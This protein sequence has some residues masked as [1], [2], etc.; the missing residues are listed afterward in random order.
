MIITPKKIIFIGF[1]IRFFNSFYNGFIGLTIGASEDSI[2]FHV[3]AANPWYDPEK[4]SI[5]RSDS[6]IFNGSYIYI[7]FLEK[8][9][10]ITTDHLFIGSFSSTIIWLLSA[11]LLN[12]TAD[13]L[14]IIKKHQKIMFLIY[15]LLPSA[16]LYTSIP[17]REPLQLFFVNLVIYLF[18]NIYYRKYGGIFYWLLA[19]IAVFMLG[20]LHYSFIFSGLIG[21]LLLLFFIFYKNIKSK[22]IYGL[23]LSVLLVASYI[24][25][26]SLFSNLYDLE[27]ADQIAKYQFGLI[28][29]EYVRAV[30]RTTIEIN[31][32][33]GLMIFIP[34]A[35]FQYLIEPLPHRISTIMDF[36]LFLENIIRI[37]L[38]Y[39]AFVIFRNKK[40]NDFQLFII[41]FYLSIEIIWSLGVNNWGTASR[42]HIPSTGL[43]CLCAFMYENKHN[44]KYI[45]YKDSQDFIVNE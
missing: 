39:N 11:L 37:Y 29:A 4:Y 20:S 25:I 33:G 12:R 45:F 17:L 22:I 28:N 21:L 10:Y 40:S 2:A 31:N 44:K 30:Y 35:F 34:Q 18:I 9:Y 13:S 7:K 19:I 27:I 14:N 1:I 41:L 24:I 3:R 16:I 23:I 36:A 26:Y 15:S 38:L 43:L 6:F 5:F 32:F 8:L 42:H